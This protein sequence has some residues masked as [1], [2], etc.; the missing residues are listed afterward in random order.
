MR[1]RTDAHAG[2]SREHWE[3]DN[4]REMTVD[5]TFDQIKPVTDFINAQLAELGCSDRV[6][7]Q[8][9]VA[10]DEL[11]GNIAQYAYDPETGPATVRVDVEDDPL[12]VI[13]T[14]IDHGVPYDP[15]SAEFVDTTHLPAKERP[16][17]GLGLYMVKKTMD[18]VSYSYQDG[19]NILTIRKRI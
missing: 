5:A 18:D 13:I 8:V 2:R 11:F 14:F 10:V 4:V 17:G 9:D 15:L 19:Q 6:R 16:V 1:Q 7:I 12:C 3:G